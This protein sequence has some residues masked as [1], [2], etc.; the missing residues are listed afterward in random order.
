MLLF[1]LVSPIF[2]YVPGKALTFKKHSTAVIVCE[3]IGF[4]P[5]VVQ[6]SKA[7]SS[8]PEGRSVVDKGRLT[9]T[10]FTLQDS[11]DY[12]CKAVNKLGSVSFSTL[13]L[14]EVQGRC[15]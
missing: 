11:G 1:I 14:I 3:A 8:L 6:W 7:F 10:R 12:Q 13:L 5:P 15:R 2:T 4:P 9:I